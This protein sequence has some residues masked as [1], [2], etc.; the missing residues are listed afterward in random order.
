MNDQRLGAAFRAVRVRRGLRQSDVAR[1]ADLAAST[2]SAVEH[3]WVDACTIRT[4]RR[5]ARVL[6]IRVELDARIQHGELARIAN[7]G[8]AAL[9]EFVAR[10]LD[11]CPG[12]VHAPEVSFAVYSERGVIDILAFHEPTAS[13]LVI[14]LKTE[15]VDIENLL[16]TMDV[17][18]RHARTIAKDRGWIA[19]SV[20]AWIVFADTDV[21]KRRIRSHA[22][23]LRSA[24][25]I[26]GRNMRAWLA[27]PRGAVRAISF[28]T[29]F[30]AGDA[31]AKAAVRRRVRAPAKACEGA[32]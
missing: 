3:G 21:N 2:V 12:W 16:S 24:F 6:D 15:L 4:L 22:A 20:S 10:H 30:A 27:S 26:D 14:E 23:T 8:H 7:A 13:L 29:N 17:R 19:K 1:L 31:I 28:A 25:P 32:V 11:G 18:V 5:I 9:H